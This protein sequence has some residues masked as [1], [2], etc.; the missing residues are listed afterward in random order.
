M[1]TV[2]TENSSPLAVIYGSGDLAAAL[3]RILKKQQL[4]LLWLEKEAEVLAVLEKPNYIFF[5]VNDQTPLINSKMAFGEAL[6]SARK[7]GAKVVLVLENTSK[8]IEEPLL[9]EK[10]KVGWPVNVVEIRGKMDGPAGQICERAAVKLVQM[11]F[12]A[13]KP[14]RQVIVGQQ[15]SVATVTSP[16]V[17]K[18]SVQDVFDQ[19]KKSRKRSPWRVTKVI[20]Q[21][22]LLLGILIVFSPLLIQLLVLGRA[23]INLAGATQSLKKG[24]FSLAQKQSLA[25]RTD[26]TFSKNLAASIGSWLVPISPVLAKYYDFLTVGESV[27]DI[28]FRLARL[29]VPVDQLSQSFLAGKR[30][31]AATLAQIRSDLGPIN[32]DLGLLEASLPQVTAGRTGTILR[33][34]GAPV[35]KINHYRREITVFRQG[36]TQAENFLAVWDD[37]VPPT[38]TRTYLL[39]FQN[40]AELRPTGGFIG[41]Y[42]LVKFAS[43]K[44]MDWKIYDVYTA[45]NQLRG[46]INPPDEI[47]H[48][49][50]QPNWYLRDANWAADWELTA[51]RLSWFLEKETGEKVD[52][53]IG[54]N[55]ATAQKIL[56]VTGPLPLPDLNQ[57]VSENDFF[58]KA[59]YNA[60]INF[61]AGSTGK[62]DFLG[63]TANAILENLTTDSAKNLPAVS[64]AFLAS[65][66]EKEILLYF[67][68]PAVQKAAVNSGWSGTIELPVCQQDQKNCL[69]LVEA[70]LGANKA[71]YFLKRSLR[72]DA[73]ISKGGDIDNLVTILYQNDS[74]SDTWPGGPYKNYLR[75]LIPHG[76]QVTGFSL[77]DNRK[78]VVSTLLTATELTKVGTDE[79]FVFQATESGFA[80]FGTLVEIPVGENKTVVFKY[81]LPTKLSFTQPKNDFNFY[82]LKQPGTNPDFLDYTVEYPSFLAPQID[83]NS[84]A[85]PLV[86]PQKLVYNSDN[87]TDRLFEIK[88]KNTVL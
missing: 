7:V 24:N 23:G 48:F 59:E 11:A 29:G 61:F 79:F 50:G 78:P 55:L 49:L 2:E 86:F 77:G 88:F 54:I 16:P 1:I 39:V 65:L 84:A 74:P 22:L 71:N 8:T 15:N 69:M 5:F 3:S 43:G 45:D 66:N 28:T 42:G 51:K 14:A 27:T 25:A 64:Q 75:F 31:P 17:K 46:Q 10:A 21:L 26:V 58:Q 62:K 83:S 53:V 20:G 4:R 80:S 82:F 38:E 76:S 34:L 40:G 36:V 35:D 70:N 47:L 87:Q 9:L 32:L 81:R 33:F 67:K 30:I 41:S 19:L 6:S 57:T 72:V 44:L 18:K 13:N 56:R 37:I 73:T 52:G 85:A 63:A 60:E 68:T 12:A